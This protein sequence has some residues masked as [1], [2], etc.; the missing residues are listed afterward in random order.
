MHRIII[1]LL[2][3]ALLAPTARAAAPISLHVFTVNDLGAADLL[4][5][6]R[7]QATIE[8]RSDTPQVVTLAIGVPVDLVMRGATASVGTVAIDDRFSSPGPLVYA[9]WSGNVSADRP[10][11]VVVS[12][13]VAT[14]AAVGDRT[15]QATATLD[16]QQRIRSAAL[17][18]ICCITAPPPSPPG[19]RIY[20][21]AIR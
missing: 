5:G 16:G 20:L 10:I 4:P 15:I 14:G 1:A 13:R 11:N 18:R 19:W 21:P 8:L 3:L 12:Y 7:G 17:V 9:H 6:G 2:A